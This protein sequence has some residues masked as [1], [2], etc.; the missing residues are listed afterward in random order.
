MQPSADALYGVYV[1]IP[2]C[3]MLCTYCDF[4]KYKGLDAW[5]DRYVAAV[6]SEAGRWQG[7]L[8]PGPPASL[9]LG[10]GTPSAL[11]PERLR[12]LIEGLCSRLL[13]A[14]DAEVCVELNPEDV[15]ERLV[16][17]LL[18]AGC[19][20][21]SLGI[22]AFDDALLRRLG[23]LH[24]GA[25]AEQAVRTLLASGVASVSADLMCGLPGQSADGWRADLA[26]AIELGLPHLSC[27]ALT[28]EPATPLA[29]QVRRG[30]LS[31]PD[32]DAAA[33]MYDDACVTLRDAGYRHYE[34]S[35]W[36]LPG[37]ESLHN[38]LYWQGRDYL[39]LGAGAVGCVAGRRW[40]NERQVER[41]CARIEAGDR[42]IQDEERL[43]TAERAR[44][45]VLLSLRTSDGLDLARF[46][47]EAGYALEGATA[48]V[49]ERLREAGMLRIEDGRLSVPECRWAVLHGI[50]TEIIAGMPGDGEC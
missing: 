5:Y 12:R 15:D 42:A 4:V 30:R 25:Q 18:E 23:R 40:W 20:R 10:G 47:A 7:D 27:Y 22:Q 2:F 38:Q 43:S 3:R 48:S 6:L 45:L 31:V 16:Q 14:A 1:H 11:G 29:R 9:F 35:N 44:E 21:L 26:R 41:Y 46:A 8:P 13:I 49:M 19:N 39:G 36:A 50:V 32:D 33:A 34:V 28:L 37:H 24:S 17:T